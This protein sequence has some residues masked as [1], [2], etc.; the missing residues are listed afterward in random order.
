MVDPKVVDIKAI[1]NMF[2]QLY[3]WLKDLEN[4]KF[5]NANPVEKESVLNGTIVSD[6]YHLD[7]E[8]HTLYI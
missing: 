7:S 4:A 1:Q 8:S 6:S 5:L 2:M 3:K